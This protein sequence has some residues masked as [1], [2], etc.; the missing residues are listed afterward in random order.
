MPSTSSAL[1]VELSHGKVGWRD[2]ATSHI[3]PL[4]PLVHVGLGF[5]LASFLF[6]LHLQ[7][8]NLSPCQ[9][10][11][12]WSV[13]VHVRL[14]SLATPPAFPPRVFFFAPLPVIP[15]SSHHYWL[16]LPVSS[17]LCPSSLPPP[18]AALLPMT[19]ALSSASLLPSCTPPAPISAAAPSVPAQCAM[20]AFP[21]PCWFE[22]H[23]SAVH[24]AALLP[25][26]G[27]CVP[28][29]SLASQLR[30]LIAVCSSAPGVISLSLT[31]PPLPREAPLPRAAPLWG[32]PQGSAARG[33]I[34]Y[35]G[36]C[37]HRCLCC[38]GSPPFCTTLCSVRALCRGRRCPFY[39][40][41]RPTS[42]ILPL[43]LAVLSAGVLRV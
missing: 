27:R 10:Q 5:V 31:S 37:L 12:A 20:A 41:L 34:S 38:L 13:S 40:C 1:S 35:P 33:T 4:P 3:R 36:C 25:L 32:R 24:H 23:C 11:L 30:A 39:E 22:L 2:P 19:V 15:S 29:R 14:L 43:S 42:P 7:L 6:N 28:H 26:C 8:L 21:A 18:A 16:S 17:A 9:L